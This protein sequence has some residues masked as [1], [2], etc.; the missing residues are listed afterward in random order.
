V[1]NVTFYKENNNF[2]KAGDSIFIDSNPSSWK[3]GRVLNALDS[4]SAQIS[5]NI[6]VLQLPGRWQSLCKPAAVHRVHAS[7]DKDTA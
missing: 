1:K 5:T 2:G 4:K 7:Q 3:L 6:A